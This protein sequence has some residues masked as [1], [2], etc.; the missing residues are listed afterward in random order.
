MPASTAPMT[1]RQR[2]ELVQL[3]CV[4]A[5]S[6][7]DVRPEEREVVRDLALHLALPEADL[8]TVER[9]LAHGPPD[10]DPYNIPRAHRDAY[11]Q[12]FLEVATADG[13]FDPEESG[14]LRVLRELLA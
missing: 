11:L 1:P 10:F 14:L 5:W 4:A 7:A 3:A 13:R 8:A 12:A 6:D 2:L 9:W